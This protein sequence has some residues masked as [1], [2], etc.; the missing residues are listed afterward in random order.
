MWLKKLK[1]HRRMVR[2]AIGSALPV[3]RKRTE[4][5][6]WKLYRR[7]SVRGRDLGATGRFPENSSAIPLTGSGSRCE[8]KCRSARLASERF[9]SPSRERKIALGLVVNEVFVP[10]SYD[11]GVEAQATA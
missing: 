11:W 1:V 9:G 3:P 8:R 7:G 5:L 2:E 4:R 10:Q 6:R